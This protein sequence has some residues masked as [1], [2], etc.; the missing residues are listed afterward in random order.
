MEVHKGNNR[1]AQSYVPQHYPGRVTL[2][3]A[4]EQPAEAPED[5]TL[6]LGELAGE[7]VDFHIVPG[8]HLTML[9]K[10]NVQVLAEQLKRCLTQAQPGLSIYQ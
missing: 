5:L 1:A 10:P 2:L 9:R 7:G 6:G 4:A 8:K 3:R